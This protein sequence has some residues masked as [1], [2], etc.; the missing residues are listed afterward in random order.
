[1]TGLLTFLALGIYGSG[2]WGAA[3]AA[4]E[5]A[6]L[7]HWNG[8]RRIAIASIAL[9]WPFVLVGMWVHKALNEL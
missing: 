4:S 5:S 2:C 6:P 8:A 7:H 1:M 9:A 3:I